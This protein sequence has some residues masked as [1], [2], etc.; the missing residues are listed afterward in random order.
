MRHP[1]VEATVSEFVPNDLFVDPEQ[2]FLILTGPNMGG[3]STF[4]RQVALLQ[5]MA[6]VGSFV[7]A[8]KATLPIVDKIFARIGASD[9]ISTGKSTFMVE[10]SE[11]AYI[12]SQATP[13]SLVIL[14]EVGRGTSTYEGISLAWGIAQYI[15]HEIGCTTIFTTHFRELTDLVEISPKYINYKVNLKEENNTIYFLHTVT[16]GKSDKSYGIQVAKLVNL[17]EQIINTAFEV[18]SSFEEKALPVKISQGS[19]AHLA[20]RK[21]KNEQQLDF[22]AATAEAADLKYSHLKEQLESL[23]TNAMTPLEAL[24]FIEKLKK[25]L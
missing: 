3:K 16:K 17:P 8:T 1:V 5:I 22:F 15:A 21:I 23:D 12:V 14:D 18:L 11:V 25:D 7:P 4:V 10:L 6:Q 24:L 19:N 13:N 2:N 20:E 9:D